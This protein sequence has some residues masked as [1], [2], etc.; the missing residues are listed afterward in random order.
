MLEEKQGKAGW[1]IKNEGKE[2][3]LFFFLKK[4]KPKSRYTVT[5]FCLVTSRFLLFIKFKDSVMGD[6]MQHALLLRLKREKLSL[7][8]VLVSVNPITMLI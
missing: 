6:L 4:K 3:N 8:A 1:A 7:Y 2:A 5:S